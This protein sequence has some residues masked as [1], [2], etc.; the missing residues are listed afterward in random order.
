MSEGA[1]LIPEFRIRNIVPVYR[2]KCTRQV[3]S[4]PRASPEGKNQGAI[5]IG[6]LDL[7]EGDCKPQEHSAHGAL[8]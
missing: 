2:T 6:D 1:A 4:L 5:K 8:Y 7:D 3:A